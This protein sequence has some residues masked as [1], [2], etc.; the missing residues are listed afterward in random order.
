[1]LKAGET[2][3]FVMSGR[4]KNFNV[5]RIFFVYE[6]EEARKVMSGNPAESERE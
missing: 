4:S 2:Y 6:D 1:M 3:E 5:D